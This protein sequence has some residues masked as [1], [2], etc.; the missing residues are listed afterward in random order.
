MRIILA[1]SSPFRKELFARLLL[2]FECFSPHID[3][4]SKPGEPHEAL[5]RRLSEEK[6]MKAAQRFPN[7]LC[8]GADEIAS[9]NG[10]ILLK[11]ENHETAIEHLRAMRD[12]WVT[13]LTGTSVFNPK[14]EKTQTIVVPTKIHFKPLT[15]EM[16]ENYLLKVKPYQCA[17]SFQSE[18]LGSALI[19]KFESEDP[20]AI[21]GLPLIALTKILEEA[22]VSV[23]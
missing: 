10:S 3:E 8:I 20:T 23:L 7:S 19:D 12:K 16:I 14:T 5:V 1:S 18:T 21:I 17:A 4:S 15:D 9:F 11:P 13:F 22:G 6:A 2:P